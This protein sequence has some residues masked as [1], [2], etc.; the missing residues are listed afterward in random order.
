MNIPSLVADSITPSA[1]TIEARPKDVGNAHDFYNILKELSDSGEIS[2]E[3]SDL[4]MAETKLF[5]SRLILPTMENVSL[6][7]IGLDEQLDSLFDKNGIPKDPPVELKYSFSQNNVTVYGNR[8]DAD[9][10]ENLIN[11]DSD[12]KEYVRTFLAISSHATAM[13]ES[14]EFQEEYRRSN[15]ADEIIR[16]YSY[17]FNDDRK[18]PEVSYMYGSESALLSGGKLFSYDFNQSG[19]LG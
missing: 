7:A 5:E 12:L 18:L 15:G 8:E 2:I 6:L 4:N 13:Q 9:E 14:L 3:E 11:A 17:L 10:I 16:K 1:Q 19:G